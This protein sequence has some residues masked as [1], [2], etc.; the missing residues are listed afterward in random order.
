MKRI[1]IVLFSVFVIGLFVILYVI[2][3]ENKQVFYNQEFKLPKV[4]FL[5]TGS[6]VGNGLLAEGVVIALQTFNKHGALVELA[7]R[8]ALL[9]PESLDEYSILI[10]SSA[11]GYHDVDRQYSLTF[12][13]DSEL[14]II[15]AWVNN[16]GVLIAGDNIGRNKIDATDRLGDFGKLSPE[17]WLLGNCFGVVL[18]ERN[19]KNYYVEGNIDDKITGTFIPSLKEERWALVIDSVTSDK[20]KILANWRHKT[21]EEYPAIIENECGSGISFL[22]PSSYLLHP[23]NVGGYW[24]AKEIEMFYEY[25]LKRY[26]N[27]QENIIK[28]NPWPNA[29]NAAFCVS[30]NGDGT[31]EEFKRIFSL[32]KKEHIKPTLFVNGEIKQEIIGLLSDS[33]VNIESNGFNR[34]N[35]REINFSTTIHEIL[36]NENNWNK[37]FVGFRFPYTRN[38]VWGMIS[39]DQLGYYFDSSIGADNTNLFYG[40]VFPYNIPV[41]IDNFYKSLNLLEISPTFHDDYYFYKK[42]IE[43]ENYSAEQQLKDSRL[44]EKYLQNYWEYSTKPYNGIMV[45][46]GHPMYVG[47]NDTTIVPLINLINTVRHDNAWI[48]SLEELADYWHNLKKLNFMINEKDG[49][50]KI[51]IISPTDIGVKNASLRF[52]TKPKNIKINIGNYKIVERE[53]VFYLIFDAVNGQEIECRF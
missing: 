22:L 17:N 45:F 38:S 7:S 40:S 52:D 31:K 8:E 10:L 19:I 30:I 51:S 4:L 42:L 3:S 12:L 43:T 39:L 36:M 47:H 21:K 49:N 6:N 11:I 2:K 27:R 24:S 23:A 26:N 46:I 33:E 35:Y 44:F 16:G 9:D 13:S 32:L 25:V 18:K 50:T 20:I 29:F 48:T 37:K 14:K 5:T 53:S 15:N 28:L 1:Y 34:L 41:S